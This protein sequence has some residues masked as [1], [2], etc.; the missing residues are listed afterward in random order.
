[1]TGSRLVL[2][3]HVRKH[4]VLPGAHR[5]VPQARHAVG[6]RQV[7]YDSKTHLRN[8]AR[9]Q[10][11]RPVCGL[12]TDGTQLWPGWAHPVSGSAPGLRLLVPNS[13]QAACDPQISAKLQIECLQNFKWNRCKTSDRMP[14]KLQMEPLQNFRYAV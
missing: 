6:S 14:A 3:S 2:P 8:R 1:M 11:A 10:G 13:R 4:S 5:L 9:S 7:A 12:S